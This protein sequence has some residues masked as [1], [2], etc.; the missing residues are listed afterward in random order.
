MKKHIDSTLESYTPNPYPRKRHL[1][2]W[3]KITIPIAAVATAVAVAVPI[4]NSTS[5]IGGFI[6]RLRGTYVDMNNVAAFCIWSAPDKENARPKLKSFAKIKDNFKLNSAYEDDESSSPSINSDSWTEEQKEQYE[7]EL[8]YDWDPENA[9]VLI[10]MNDDGSVKEVVYERTNGRGQVRQDT[11]ANAAAVFTSKNF[12]YV[13]YVDDA[14]WEFWKDVNYAQEIV[15]PNG[16]KTTQC[17]WC[18]QKMISP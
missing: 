11:L 6:N 5:G 15:C 10:S 13:M 17:K 1:P 16:A 9:S 4:I 2:L 7:W 12:T 18:Q 14:E 3:A 8:D